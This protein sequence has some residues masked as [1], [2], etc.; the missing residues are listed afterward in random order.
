MLATMDGMHAAADRVKL[1]VQQQ[2][3]DLRKAIDAKEQVRYQGCAFVCAQ[4]VVMH[5]PWCVK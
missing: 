1:M 5:V 2:M 3:N 4:V